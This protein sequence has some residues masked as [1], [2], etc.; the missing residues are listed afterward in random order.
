[1]PQLA[2]VRPGMFQRFLPDAGRT[3]AVE[4][5]DVVATGDPRVT[6]LGATILDGAS[7][8]ELDDAETVV[9]VGAGIGSAENL[10]VLHNLAASVNGTIAASLRAVSMGLLPGPLQVGLTGRAISPRFY[11]AVG[12]RGVLTH[13]MGV[14][15]SGTIIAINNDPA[16]E[17]FKN[18]DF[19]IVGD[20]SVIVPAVARA[21]A[22]VRPAE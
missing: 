15:K 20:F 8:V 19:G 10:A 3:G 7:G 1:R 21:A 4:Q 22:A 13:M 5:L 2:T 11:F 18:A 6:Y 12:V 17:I 14:A 16:A 9:G